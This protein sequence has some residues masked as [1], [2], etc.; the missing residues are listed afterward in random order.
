[1]SAPSTVDPRQELADL[2]NEA[3]K[4]AAEILNAS[5]ENES[6]VERSRSAMMARMMQDI[7]GKKFTIAMA[8]QVLR[9]E[10]PE[11]A[12]RRMDTL[13]EEYGLPKY[14]SWFNRTAL[15]FGNWMAGMLPNAVIPLVK[16][17]VR[18]DSEHVII[19]AEEHEFDKYLAWRKRER[20]RVNFNQLGEAVLGDQEGRSA[21]EG[22]RA[23]VV[24]A[25][26]RLHL[27]QTIFDRQPNQPYRI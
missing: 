7:P 22:Q 24:G 1:M 2:P 23:T 18:A 21:S 6:S 14:F 4:L 25:G 11:R 20:I 9:I 26:R 27:D 5:R 8:D 17:K 12:A 16:K 3:V 19:S 13:V 15:S 10:R